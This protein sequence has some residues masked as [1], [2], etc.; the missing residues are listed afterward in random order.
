MEMMR[1]L[2]SCDCICTVQKKGHN[3]GGREKYLTM[4]AAAQSSAVAFR[5]FFI[6]RK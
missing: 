2:D 1:C 4:K 3:Y 6:K 5:A